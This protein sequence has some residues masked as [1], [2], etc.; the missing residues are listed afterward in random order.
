MREPKTALSAVLPGG[1]RIRVLLPVAFC[2]CLFS[3]AAGLAQ[4][5]A[6]RPANPSIQTAARAR[7]PAPP[8]AQ[9][10]ASAG[11]ASSLQSLVSFEG[12]QLSVNATNVSLADVLFAVR[13]ATGADIDIPMNASAERVTAQLGPGPARKVLSDLLAWSSFDYIIQGSDDD[14]LAVQSITLM[15]RVKSAT[16]GAI[17]AGTTPTAARQ[18]F[19]SRAETESSPAAMPSTDVAAV[20]PHSDQPAAAAPD[21]PDAPANL[22][23]KVQ[24]PASQPWSSGASSAGRSP[25][26]MIQE[27]QQMYQQ[28]RMLQEQQNQG[29][30]QRAP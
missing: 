11:A 30:G 10:P 2:L 19:A 15:V 1:S 17:V 29:S 23:P 3:T 18:A 21:A 25:S 24:S 9:R 6:G 7:V 14:P 22:Q 16:P 8:A 26:D 5:P 13:G 12:G 20:E 4:D 28:R 27:L